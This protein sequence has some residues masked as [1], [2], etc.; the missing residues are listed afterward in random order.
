MSLTIER[1]VFEDSTSAVKAGIFS[2]NAEKCHHRK[3][4]GIP[5]RV[6]AAK[7]YLHNFPKFSLGQRVL[8]IV[9]SI[10]IPPLKV[11]AE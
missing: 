2:Y 8:K 9:F 3:D 7:F 1:L 10:S 5:E 4:S 6:E 11:I